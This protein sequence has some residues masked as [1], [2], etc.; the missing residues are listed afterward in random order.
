[1]EGKRYNFRTLN[2]RVLAR[3]SGF[4]I[5]P[6][7]IEDI[8]HCR[9][10]AIE[11]TLF[12]LQFAMAD[13]KDK[14]AKKHAPL[15]SSW[16]TLPLQQQQQQQQQRE[17]ENQHEPTTNNPNNSNTSGGYHQGYQDQRVR[18][19]MDEA[20]SHHPSSHLPIRSTSSTNSTTNN[21]NTSFSSS[22]SSPSKLS[23]PPSYLHQHQYYQQQQQQQ[24]QE[25][26]EEGDQLPPTSF[27]SNPLYTTSSGDDDEE[28]QE[29]TFQAQ[30]QS[31]KRGKH[32]P[33][34]NPPSNFQ[35]VNQSLL[36][37]Y[38]RELEQQKE[39]ATLMEE[40]NAKLEQLLRIKDNR[41]QRLQREN[42]E[43]KRQLETNT[44]T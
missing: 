18:E 26:G 9:D 25:E 44:T 7:D 21:N 36:V 4:Q 20:L 14:V 17:F 32:G 8:I 13:L 6:L 28:E 3:L 33:N 27:E 34:P 31:H 40:K 24:Q 1:M 29:A 41:I 37:E 11:R 12:A 30:S 2:K 42:E 35:Q 38:K 43:L 5:S 19:A 16:Q 39:I 22:P 23:T 10:G 15:S